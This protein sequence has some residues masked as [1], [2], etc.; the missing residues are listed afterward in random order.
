MAWFF[1]KKKDAEPAAEQPTPEEEK[2]RLEGPWDSGDVEDL[3]QRLDAGSL[4]IPLV[5]GASLQF[6]LDRKRRQVLG[7]VFSKNNSALQLQV[8]SSPRSRD[9]WDEV[10]RDMQTSIA[11]QGGSSQEAQGEFGTEL[12][13][14]MPVANSK[15]VAPYRFI[16][17]DGPR[18]LLRATIY[19]RAG[20]DDE[21]AKEM[22][23]IIKDVV[24]HRGQTPHPP[25]ELLPLEIP[26]QIK[27]QGDE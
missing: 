3:G 27:N 23:D 15:N 9:I 16:G 5:P 26:Q 18:W 24:V 6:S 21:A 17:I 13:A 4:W 10:R 12:R 11:K 14:N 20:S 1:R 7:I 8:F 25:R 19:G 2:A 22:Y